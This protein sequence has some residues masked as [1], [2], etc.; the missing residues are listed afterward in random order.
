MSDRLNAGDCTT[1]VVADNGQTVQ[2]AP[3]LMSEWKTKLPGL[4]EVPFR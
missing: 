1:A 2:C 4:P 3:I